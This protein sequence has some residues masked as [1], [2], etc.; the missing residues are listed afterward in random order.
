M[1]DA[2]R[3]NMGS[4]FLGL[5]IGVAISAP[6]VWLL[7]RARAIHLAGQVTTLQERN[8]NLEQ[9]LSENQ[10]LDQVIK[11]VQSALEELKFKSEDADRRRIEAET[12]L[13][14]EMIHI[15]ER[16]ESLESAT[17]QIAAALAKGQSRGQYGEMQLEQLLQHAGLL[18]G[19]HYR[20][21]ESR[22]FDDRTQRPDVTI[23]L[24][25]GGEVLVD[26]KF[27]WDAFFEA[28]GCEEPLE[29]EN[30]LD[31]HAKDL[32]KRI[33]ELASKQYQSNSDKS[34][35]FVV[36]FLPFESLLSTALD[37]DGLLLEKAFGKNVIPATPTTMLG[38]L[39][40]IS[41]GWDQN[42]LS[43]NA[44]EIRAMGAEMLKR[45]GTLVE[46]I[47]KLGDGL[48]KAVGGYNSFVS[49]F[50]RQA[51]TQA[52]RLAEKGVPAAKPLIA[53]DEITT[54]VAQVRLQI[55]DEK[56]ENQD[57]S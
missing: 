4:L 27:P 24:A 55:E 8:T 2:R 49:S 51:V 7:A 29:R 33:N 25:G 15:K 11:P 31:K 23:L 22:A 30:L 9:K 35:N 57:E 13:K 1:M 50:D 12:M 44:E 20:R 32:G 41:F 45:L 28:M 21:Q 6:I 38:L 56:I 47:E 40:T 18:E 26:A 36:L 17:K 39:R 16:N 19:T 48:N 53:P 3:V 46:H 37:M 5:V 34:P 52:K 42:N 14:R 43:A 54:S 10:A